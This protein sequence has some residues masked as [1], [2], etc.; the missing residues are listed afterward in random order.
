MNMKQLKNRK[1]IIVSSFLIVFLLGVTLGYAAVP[2]STTWLQTGSFATP[3]TYTFWVD[4]L[5]YFCRNGETGRVY[6]NSNFT[7]LFN[8]VYVSDAGYFFKAGEYPVC[9]GELV[10]IEYIFTEGLLLDEDNT[11][12]AG[13]GK[14][15]VFY[16]SAE[17]TRVFTVEA[18]NVTIKDVC[19]DGKDINDE[20]F[21]NAADALIVFGN[22]A[23]NCVLDSCHLINGYN[24]DGA[25]TYET[26]N[27]TFSNNFVSENEHGLVFT[28]T[29]NSRMYNNV[30]IN[31]DT[32]GILMWGDYTLQNQIYGNFVSDCGN[33]GIESG[34]NATYNKI[35]D[36]I[37]VAC[38]KGIVVNAPTH[39]IDNNLVKGCVTEGIYINGTENSIRGCDAMFSTDA[40]N[41]MGIRVIDPS[42]ASI[43]FGCR[44]RSN[45]AGNIII[46]SDAVYVGNC[47]NDTTYLGVYNGTAWIGS[48]F[49]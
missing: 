37:I 32:N 23:Y 13:E 33:N 22:S 17:Y 29:W 6:D 42:D 10:A 34:Y 3:Y 41:G 39:Y 14:A 36:N 27:A 24:V 43:V 31:C 12:I 30:V 1:Y 20:Q 45:T 48:A 16:P 46:E 28:R 18:E 5:N 15:T 9:E 4:G 11:V 26:N 7:T 44:A 47:L 25:G 19:L 35:N 40:T 8:S 21:P 2:S 38:N 49:P